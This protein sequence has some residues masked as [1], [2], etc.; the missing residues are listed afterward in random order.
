MKEQRRVVDSDC[1]VWVG[2]FLWGVYVLF[3]WILWAEELEISGEVR[4]GRKTLLFVVPVERW[5]DIVDSADN[6]LVP[7]I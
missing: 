2:E 5:G 4:Y 7:S 3:E 1:G 6:C